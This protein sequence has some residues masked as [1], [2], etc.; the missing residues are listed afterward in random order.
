[1]YVGR[2]ED[3]TGE[4]MGITNIID[5]RK[6]RHRWAKVNAIV[7]AT[8]HDNQAANA[9]IAPQSAQDVEYD[10]LEGVSLAEAVIWAQGMPG[11][12]T[13]FIYDDG[14]GTSESGIKA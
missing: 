2:R 9:D 4:I 11:A 7:E 12:I 1:M 14:A 8:W 3:C 10:Q 5:S 6:H 13:L